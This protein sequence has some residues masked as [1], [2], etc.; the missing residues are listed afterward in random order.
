MDKQMERILDICIEKLKGG[1]PLDEILEEYPEYREELKDLLT[2]A[3][4][5]ENIPLP[6][7]RDEA[8]A[9]CLV[10]V[11]DVL[12]LQKKPVWRARRPRLQWSRFFYLPSPAWAKA[13]AFVLIVFLISWGAVS[14][15]AGSIPGNL[16]YPVKLMGEN[17]RFYSTI[18]PEEKAEL[19][20]T[21]SEV[22]MQE[23]VR[24]LDEKGELNSKVLKAML[25]EAA[26]VT[27]NVSRL[28]KDKAMVCCL[29]L[30]H[31]CA[32]HVEVL[33]R[34]KSRVPPLQRQELVNAIRTCQQR[35]EWMGKVIR[36]E[37]P[38]GEWG[39]FAR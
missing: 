33:E 19:R 11:L 12:Q 4:G 35:M 27:D 34:L 38:I 5:I 29:K 13:L 16:L 31:L 8:V 22:R 9:S 20:L 3:K 14:L 18:D 24:Y 2:I 23:L 21:Y 37:V 17:I 15:S 39:P 6:P 32:F 25:D 10:K 7:V 1:I 30:E 26:L 36:N 28:P